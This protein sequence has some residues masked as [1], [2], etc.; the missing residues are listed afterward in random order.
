[1]NNIELYD[2]IKN[3]ELEVDRLNKLNKALEEKIKKFEN[4]KTNENEFL[5]TKGFIKKGKS[6]GYLNK[7]QI[8]AIGVKYPVQKGWEESAIGKS[9]TKE[10]AKE[11]MDLKGI[12]PKDY[13]LMKHRENKEKEMLKLAGIPFQYE[14]SKEIRNIIKNKPI[15]KNGL[16]FLDSQ[17]D[18][19]KNGIS[20]TQE[21]IKKIKQSSLLF[22]DMDMEN[23]ETY[24]YIAGEKNNSKNSFVKIGFTKNPRQRIKS[25]KTAKPNIELLAY[26]KGTY[27]TEQK[28]HNKFKEYRYKGE[29]FN[30][31]ISQYH[32]KKYFRNAI[33]EVNQDVISAKKYKEILIKK[34]GIM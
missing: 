17:L 11:F 8:L 9:I 29:W 24:V 32:I 27:V 3:L 28:L 21:N 20:I 12:S 16:A 22:Y 10:K 6:H 34:W 19:L 13:A 30:L 1:M 31:P 15:N 25:L 4:K 26:E 23:V 14:I 33:D 2:K 5:I 7:G 18:L